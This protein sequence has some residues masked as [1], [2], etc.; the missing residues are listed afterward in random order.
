M[1]DWIANDYAEIAARLR[2]L[3]EEKAGHCI[4]CGLLGWVYDFGS[5]RYFVCPMCKNP[6]GNVRPTEREG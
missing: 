5:H 6:R 3:E 2:R 4:T 1:T